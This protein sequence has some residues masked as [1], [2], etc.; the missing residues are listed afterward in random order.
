MTTT[1]PGPDALTTYELA[2]PRLL[3]DGRLTGSSD[4]AVFPNI[5]PATEE[6][7]GL[8]FDATADDIDLAITAAR[9]A[10]DETGWATDHAFR[11][12]CLDRKSVV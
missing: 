1:K 4:E 8:T 7:I 9:R 3:I 12:H 6:V 11:K 10:F 5:N 2:E